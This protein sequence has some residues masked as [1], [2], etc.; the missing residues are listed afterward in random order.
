MTLQDFVITPLYLIVIYL[1]AYFI[2]GLVADA[3][4]KRYFIPALTV[5]IIGAIAVGLIYQFYYNG[6][7]T[8]N[9]F[10]NSKHI[11]EAFKDSP[12]LGMSLIL[13]NNQYTSANFQYAS[14]MYFFHDTS[15]YFVVRVAGLFDI[16]TLHTYSATAV[17]FAVFSFSGL[18]AM[19]KGFC[20]L[21]KN[22]H[23]EFALAIFFVPSVFF[24]GSGILKDTLTLGALGWA[25]YAAIRMFFH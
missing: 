18:W 11:W 7:D 22:L 1:V 3:N 2:R 10:N 16:L 25:T 23:F 17:L 12:S 8:F 9:Y 6:G 15:S 19:Y 20:D 14:L 5:K 13:S 21:Y 4:T 24:W